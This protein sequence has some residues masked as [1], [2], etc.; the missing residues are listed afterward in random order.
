MSTEVP[1]VWYDPDSGTRE[2]IGNCI[3]EDDGTFTAVIDDELVAD[4]LQESITGPVVLVP[5][6]KEDASLW[7]ADYTPVQVDSLT[8]KKVAEHESQEQDNKPAG[9]DGGSAS[10]HVRSRELGFG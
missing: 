9:G 1:L 6:V 4:A 5:I 7:L 10:Y 2:V 3:V 8:K